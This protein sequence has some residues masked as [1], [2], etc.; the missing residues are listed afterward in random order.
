MLAEL[1]AVGSV[2]WLLWL[3]RVTSGPDW[4][5]SGMKPPPDQWHCAEL[6]PGQVAGGAQVIRLR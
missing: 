2:A 6:W 5:P 1:F 3:T 4:L